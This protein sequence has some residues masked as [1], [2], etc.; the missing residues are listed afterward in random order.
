[1]ANI[2]INSYNEILGNMIRKIISD[3]PVN[4]INKGSLLLTLLEAA[5]AN[6]Y[7]N[8]TS[9]LNVL[10]LLNIDALQN[11][12]LDAYASNFGLKRNTAAKASGFVKIIDSTITKRSTTLYPVK[13][14]PI[15]GTTV[16]H[17][18]DATGWNQTGV[19]YLGRG[20]PNFEGPLAYTSITDNGTFFTIQLS[21]A[22]EKDHLISETVVDG[23]RTLANLS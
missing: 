14:A 23:K 18:N 2:N 22:L 19:V 21:S 13:P 20:T 5:A 7:E 1:M 3:T 16:L 9:I 12:D 8:N 4:D 17:V 11:N 6:D 10:E 15:T